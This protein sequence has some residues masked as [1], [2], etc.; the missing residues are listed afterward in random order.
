[1]AGL[2][3]ARTLVERGHT[4]TVYEA[5]GRVGGRLATEVLAGGARA[6]SGAQFFTVR[7]PRF[8][9]LVDDLVADGVV[10]V[11]C[12]GFG[13]EPDGY[14]RFVGVGGMAALAERLAAGL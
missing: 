6:D 8:G 11:W 7:T 2:T 14:P 10:R 3:A 12:R 13:P 1:M 4:I 5:A 9:S